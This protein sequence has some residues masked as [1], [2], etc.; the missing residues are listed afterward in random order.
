MFITYWI[1]LSKKYKH[2]NI[3]AIVTAFFFGY[4]VLTIKPTAITDADIMPHVQRPCE[5]FS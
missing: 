1:Y 3:T 4:G 2:S 5:M